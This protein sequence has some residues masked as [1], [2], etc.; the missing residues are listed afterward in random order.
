MPMFKKYKAHNSLI[1]SSTLRNQKKE[2]KLNPSKQGEK[3]II[4]IRA[5]LIKQKMKT[6]MK[7]N[8]LS[9]EPIILSQMQQEKEREDTNDRK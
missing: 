1:A 4:K 6:S 7:Q 9:V 5:E 2:G 3:K 8:S